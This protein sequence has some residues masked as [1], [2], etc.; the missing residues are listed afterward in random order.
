MPSAILLFPIFF[1]LSFFLFFSFLYFTLVL[2]QYWSWDQICYQNW[3]FSLMAEVIYQVSWV[4]TLCLL[5]SPL[6][7]SLFFFLLIFHHPSLP[8]TNLSPL[9]RGMWWI[10]HRL[11][12][13]PCFLFLVIVCLRLP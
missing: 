3:D 10:E 6:F 2:S 11:G 7:V 1:L 9:G 5:W 13:M 8:P 12:M 4:I